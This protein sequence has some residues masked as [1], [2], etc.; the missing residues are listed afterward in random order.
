MFNNGTPT[1]EPRNRLQEQEVAITRIRLTMLLKEIRQAFRLLAKNPGF[2][3]IAALSLALGI[4][5]NSAIF[6]LVDAILLRPLPVHDPG[7]VVNVP[8]DTPSKPFSGV[9]FPDY[10][11]HRDKNRSLA[12]LV[13]YQFS[14]F[15]FASSAT[16]TPQM[17]LGTLVSDNFFDVLGIQ[18]A[19]GRGF[20]PDEG[21]VSG[22]DAT[23]ILSHDFWEFQFAR[24]PSAIGR[25]VRLNGID[26]TIVG[27]LPP[28][29]T[30]IDQWVQ[31][32][33]Y[34]PSTM[35]QRLSAAA[36]DT[37]E[38][39]DDRSWQVKDRLKPGVS[40][41][42]AQSELAG[43]PKNLEKANPNTNRHRTAVVRTELQ[44]RVQQDPPDAA[45]ATMLMAL[46]GL[47]RIIACAKVANLFLA[48]A[49]S[50]SREI[51]IRLAIGIGRLRLIRQLFVESLMLALLGCTLG[52]VFAYG[53]IRFLQRIEIPSDIP[54]VIATQLDHRVVLFS[55]LA[56]FASAL[57]F[58]LAPAWQALRTDLVP[59][60]KSGRLGASGARRTIGRNALVIG[61]VALSV[62]LLVAAG[63]LLHGFRNAPVP[64]PPFPPH[65]LLTMHFHTSSLR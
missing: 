42:A 10:R 32:A 33:L 63:M 3:A 35:S 9:S 45:M 46:S 40:R 54:V 1:K 55:L 44:S 12:G 37:L 30:T 8:T 20:L 15:G 17:R 36:K 53:G 64:N 58:G 41:Q 27:V 6:S 38:Q 48:R 29:F 34:A 24:D 31:P 22:R 39:R 4:G 21:K 16:A 65:H 62:V 56:A 5:A 14:T 51:A 26:F 49:T 52:V 28:G 47:V 60:L 43:I 25:T 61:Q 59:A 7:E 11:D 2:T 13:A 18:P 57:V 19:L 23:V 50:R